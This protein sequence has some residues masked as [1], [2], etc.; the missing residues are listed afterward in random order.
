MFRKVGRTIISSSVLLLF[1]FTCSWGQEQERTLSLTLEDAI[2]KTIQNNYAVAIQILE[3]ESAAISISQA[4][5]RFMPY[6][7][8]DGGLRSTASAAYSW[9]EG[10]ESVTT[11]FNSYGIQYSQLL[12]F[13]TSFAISLDSYKSD[14][15]A[16]FQTVNPRYGSTLRFDVRQPFLRNFGT[17]INRHEIIISQNNL[18]KSE[19]NL[20]NTLTGVVYLVE[21]AYWNL[22]YYIERL[23]VGQQALQLAQDLLAKNQRA[24]EV[25]TLAPIE[26][27][28][29][30]AEVAAREADI[31][32][33]EVDVKNQEDRLRTIMNLPEEEMKLSLPIKPLD[34][35]KLEAKEIS[36]D[37]ALVT[38]LANR[39]DLKALRIDLKNQ[40]LNVNYAKNQILPSLDL[41]A[42]YWSPGLSGTQIIYDGNP[43]DG[44][45]IGTIPGGPGDAL[46]QAFGFTYNNWAVGLTLDIPLSSI[47]SK[48]A[49]AQARVNQEQALLRLKNQEQVVYLEIRNGVRAVQTDYKRVQSYRVAR[50]LAEQKLKAEE[51]KLRV[52]L[53]TNFVVLTYQRDLSNAR[54]NELRAIVD[55]T[56]SL[57]ALDRAM[58]VSLE[59]KDILL[60]QVMG[61][62]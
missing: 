47:T 55:Y 56:L 30:Q 34:M 22:A 16:R 3:P 48:A 58:G 4:K 13:G 8:F 15:N 32:T 51:E 12:S 59:S 52:G 9:L 25:G 19:R 21:E 28:S 37:E 43:I 57:A 38:S 36:L 14:T 26:V 5:E 33:Y 35:P 60:S 24:V 29:A 11:D 46:Q 18:E 49:L 23:K 7:A 54:I 42:S 31:L 45:I 44:I 50:D 39:P 62:N 2:L 40:D 1:V 17:K 27:L 20:E 53:S 61:G 10:A 6:F 41:T